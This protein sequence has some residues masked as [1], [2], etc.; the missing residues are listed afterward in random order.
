MNEQDKN[1]NSLR[2]HV[3]INQFVLAAGCS[4]EQARQ[5][6]LSAQWQFQSALSIFFQ[7]FSP[8]GHSHYNQLCTPANT[9]ATPPNFPDALMA[10]SK[11]S[12]AERHSLSPSGTNST[13]SQ[14]VQSQ[15]QNQ[16][17]SAHMFNGQGSAS[18]QQITAG[19][20]VTPFTNQS[21]AQQI[22]SHLHSQR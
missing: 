3:M 13:S 14:P 19:N 18:S 1:E 4:R 9:P 7:E 17:H 21:P 20:G 6:L 11:W 16:Y 5:I 2:E 8:Q 22:R 15:Y 10:L 12:T